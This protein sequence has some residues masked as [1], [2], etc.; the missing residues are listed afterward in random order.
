MELKTVLR[1]S[2]WLL[3]AVSQMWLLYRLE[4][5]ASS[6]PQAAAN[7][8]SVIPATMHDDSAV[9]HSFLPT[10]D[11]DAAAALHR[12]ESRLTSLERALMGRVGNPVASEKPYEPSARERAEAD[13]RLNSLLPS[14]ILSR[15]DMAR[16]HADVQA[17][18]P[19]ERFATATAL[20]RAINEGRIQPGPGGL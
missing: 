16:F 14:A 17:L 13:Q 7:Q 8:S 20:A 15:E 18:P 2:A 11:N 12:I 6:A 1:R 3:L 5:M 10:Q 19:E 4:Q 9:P